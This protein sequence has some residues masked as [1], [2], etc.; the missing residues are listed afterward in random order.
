MTEIVNKGMKSEWDLVRM[1]SFP[2]HPLL[3]IFFNIKISF[4]PSL[5]LNTNSRAQ[6]LQE[7]QGWGELKI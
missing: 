7:N 5:V 4:H 6:K 1:D 2:W 3:S